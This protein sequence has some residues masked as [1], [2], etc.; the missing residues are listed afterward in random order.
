MNGKIKF[1]LAALAA[2][3]SLTANAQGHKISIAAHR[4]FWDCEEAGKAQNSIASLR[5]AQDNGFWGSEVDVHLTSDNIIVVNH[6]NDIHGIKIHNHPFAAF[7]DMNLKNGEKVPI[8]DDYLDQVEKCKT[9]KLVLELKSQ[10]SRERDELLAELS[11]AKLKEHGLY[12]PD[13]VMFISFSIDACDYIAKNAPEFTNQYLS[14]DL[15]PDE[16]KARGINGLDYNYSKLFRK[17][18]WIRRAHELGMTV[19][20]WTVNSKADIEKCIALGVDCI[21]TNAPLLARELL[22]DMENVISHKEC[23]K[24]AEAKKECCKK[25][26]DNKACCDKKADTRNCCDNKCGK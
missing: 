13:R 11:I 18:E 21:T 9:T 23:C 2:A 8:L 15:A 3:I 22:G 5:Q 4:G 12:T 24:K 25:E 19:N 20:A 17:P 26:A 16:L 14:G 10:G 6:D 7:K 1:T